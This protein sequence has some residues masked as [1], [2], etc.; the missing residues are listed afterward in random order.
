MPD[1]PRLLTPN[2]MCYNSD[3][4]ATEG[5]ITMTL[6]TIAVPDTVSDLLF[7]LLEAQPPRLIQDD[8]VQ[9]FLLSPDQY[10]AL[11]ELLE[12]IKDLHDAARAEAE[13][14]AGESRLFL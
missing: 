6:R 11:I 4:A 12:D 10:E 9:G 8:K 14:T 5:M 2:G 13:H 7:H 3:I 1:S